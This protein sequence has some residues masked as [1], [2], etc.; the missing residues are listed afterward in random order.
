M[1]DDERDP[2]ADDRVGDWNAER[3]KGGAGDDA[4]AD[5]AVNASVFPSAIRAGLSSRRPPHVR[6]T[7][8][9]RALTIRSCA[10]LR[11]DPQGDRLHQR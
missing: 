5:E 1:E 3:D 8:A 9:T 4:E 11:T 7:C 10:V 6:M 2:E